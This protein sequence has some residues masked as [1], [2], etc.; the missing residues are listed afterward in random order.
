M[1]EGDE[2]LF[3]LLTVCWDEIVRRIA[4]GERKEEMSEGEIALLI[5]F[6]NN[7]LE[8]LVELVNET[9]QDQSC[10]PSSESVYFPESSGGLVAFGH[11]QW[12]KNYKQ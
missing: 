6:S 11:T 10:A 5:M 8:E 2:K 12:L 1:K 7:V 4:S 3:S 9:R